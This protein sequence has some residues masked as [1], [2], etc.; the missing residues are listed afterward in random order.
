MHTWRSPEEHDRMV[1]QIPLGRMA[2]P[3]EISR[4]VVF[5]ASPKAGYITGTTLDI[6]GGTVML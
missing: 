6:S 4:G 2:E 3:E 1:A 5:L